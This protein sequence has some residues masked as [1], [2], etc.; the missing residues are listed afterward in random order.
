M[1]TFAGEGKSLVGYVRQLT[2]TDLG[3][4]EALLRG[5]PVTNCFIDARVRWA[6]LDPW[7]LGGDMW[8]YFDDDRLTSIVYAGANL[9]PIATTPASRAAFADR[10]RVMPRR[11]SSFVGPAEEVLDLWRLLEPAWGPAREVRPEQPLLVL[12]SDPLIDG[13]PHVRYAEAVELDL[14]VPACIEMFTEEVGV[15]PVRGGAGTA[16]RGRIEELVRSRRSFVRI[17]DGQLQFK[18]EVGAATTDACQVQGVWVA[19][20]LRGR[21]LSEPAMASVVRLARASISPVVSLYV[22]SFNSAALRAYEAVGFRKYGLF[23]TVLF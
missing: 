1:T 23:A 21:G 13:D 2:T 12:D 3:A 19:K 7:R 8:G 22:N 6:G 4:A 18:A 20:E 11:C 17:V 16:Y 15:S 9:V 10:L 14:V 5:D